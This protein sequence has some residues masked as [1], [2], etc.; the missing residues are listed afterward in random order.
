MKSSLLTSIALSVAAT[1]ANPVNS[2]QFSTINPADFRSG[3]HE[4]LALTVNHLRIPII[5]GSRSR[6]QQC[7]PGKNSTTYGFYAP[8]ENIMVLCT[9]N[10]SL[11]TMKQTFVHETMHLVQDCRAGLAN[12]SLR[13]KNGYLTKLQ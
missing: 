5:D 2:S 8:T 1:C 9:A 7:I 12:S 4:K 3:E 13:D 11:E 6:L 10:G